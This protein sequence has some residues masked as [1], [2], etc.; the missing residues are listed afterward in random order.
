MGPVQAT[1]GDTEKRAHG[2]RESPDSLAEASCAG[3]DE[4]PDQL[5]F[6]IGK[7]APGF[8]LQDEE[9]VDDVPCCVMVAFGRRNAW[10]LSKVHQRHRI[11]RENELRRSSPGGSGFVC[12][13]GLDRLI[14]RDR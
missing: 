3:R 2:P 1:R 8:L 12:C 14:V 11:E 10:K 7:V 5:F 4:G 6:F 13:G 9:G